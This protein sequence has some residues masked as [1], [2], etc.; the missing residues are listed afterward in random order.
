M[1]AVGVDVRRRDLEGIALLHIVVVFVNRLDEQ[2]IAAGTEHGEIELA[3]KCIKIGSFAL[4][5]C[6]H[7]GEIV[8]VQIADI[9]IQP[10]YGAAGADRTAYAEILAA[11]RAARNNGAGYRYRAGG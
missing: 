7:A 10:C 3:V 1:P 5:G 4:G 9:G 11:E 2:L 8:A 6:L